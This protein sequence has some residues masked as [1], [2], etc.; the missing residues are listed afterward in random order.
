MLSSVDSDKMVP[1][2][3]KDQVPGTSGVPSGIPEMCSV[4]DLVGD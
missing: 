3:P 1:V 2:S 4:A